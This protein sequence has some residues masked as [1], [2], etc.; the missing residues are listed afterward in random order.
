MK[1]RVLVLAV[2]GCMLGTSAMAA[3]HN[4]TDR[5]IA[6]YAMTA[7]VS[8]A[9]EGEHNPDWM[10][11]TTVNMSFQKEWKPQYE[12]E[13]IQPL[14]HVG[15]HTKDVV[16]V[17]G[18]VSNASELGTTVNI[19][20]GYRHLN[21]AKTSMIGV[22]AFYDHAFKENHSRIGGGLEYFSGQHELRAN[23]YH[24]VSGEREVDAENHVFEKVVDG[25]NVEYAHTFKGAEWA[26]VYASAY[27]WDMKHREDATGFYVGTELQL[28]PNISVDMGMNKVN[29]DS[30]K[31]FGRIMYRLGK[32]PVALWGGAHSYGVTS[33]VEA[34]LL[35]KVRRVNNIV[36]E[37]YGKG[38]NQPAQSDKLHVTLRIG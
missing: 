36:V 3:S 26:K 15:K 16:F 37:R 8:S 4:E 5:S 7:A 33:S 35:T 34:K 32:A 2:L 17:Q 24:G 13:T 12:V 11:R 29:H 38:Q 19:G 6:G 20:V 14:T 21:D 30:G 1:R 10:K 23:V 27:R 18:R 28:T 31:I 22:N 25:Y 9:L